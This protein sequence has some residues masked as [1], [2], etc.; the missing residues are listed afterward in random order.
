MAFM[1]QSCGFNQPL[2]GW[3]IDSV[4]SMYWMFRW[5]SSFDQDLGWCVDDDVSLS[6]AFTSTKCQSTSCGVT[7]GGC[8]TPRPTT[9]EPTAL[10]STTPTSAPTV[11][12][13][14]T[15]DG[16]ALYV[17]G[18]IVASPSNQ[19]ATVD[20]L[21]NYELTFTME[22][23]SD[24]SITSDWQSILHI[25][26]TNQDRLPGIW[27]SP[28]QWSGLYAAQSYDDCYPSYCQWEMFT[29]GIAFAAGETY[30]IKI[31]VEN[32]QI[33]VYVDG[34][35]RGSASGSATYAATDAAVYVG[36]PWYDAAAVTL[37]HICLKE[38]VYPS[39]APTSRP[40]LRPTPRPTPRPTI[41]NV[42]TDINIRTAV[43]AWLADAT[44]AEATYGHISTW[45]TG[46]VTDMSEL[47]DDAS[48]FNE[49]IG[50]WDTSGVTRMNHM[51]YDA[52]SFNQNLGGW[53]VHSVRSMFV[54]FRGA[55]SFNQDLG[56]WEVHN[57][58]GM[59]GMFRYAS[60]FDQDLGWCVDDDV[61]LDYAFEETKCEATSCGV[62]Q[63]DGA[64]APREDLDVALVVS[65]CVVG[66]FLVVCGIIYAKT[67]YS[68]KSAKIAAFSNNAATDDGDTITVVRM[69]TVEAAHAADASEAAPVQA[70]LVP[71]ATVLSVHQS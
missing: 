35:N 15:L 63:V 47:F 18:P 31:S 54:M 8:S 57:V 2:S 50:A 32:N 68:S 60:A 62:E 29:T 26:D 20:S 64:C 51:F 9:S 55:S 53:A 45:E 34:V 38:I 30:D 27:F 46:G 14:P 37:S 58:V 13:A 7:Q 5:A 3:N 39:P 19:V 21:Q 69:G 24:W 43:A 23:A 16:C 44:A 52:S 22:L 56:G 28:T 25:G 4:T 66:A 17:V 40:S 65:L 1:F 71:N 6:Y 61:Q 10:P 12:P 42:M 36:D 33:A 11:T 48:S 49:D 70:T 59:L 41:N 67:Y